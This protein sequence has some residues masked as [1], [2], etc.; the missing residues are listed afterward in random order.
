M[1][2]TVTAWSPGGD[3]FRITG[4]DDAGT[5]L[6]AVYSQDSTERTE[7]TFCVRPADLRTAAGREIKVLVR[8]DAA[9]E[10]LSLRLP[11]Y[12]TETSR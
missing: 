4:I 12:V 3:S 6:K 10:S 1:K 9:D 11:T 2:Q 5:G 7:I 8:L